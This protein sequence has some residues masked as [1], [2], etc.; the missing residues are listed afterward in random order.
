MHMQ[1][2]R[3]SL[4]KFGFD[5]NSL[6]FAIILFGLL[7][8]LDGYAFNR[9]LWIDESMLA[10]NIVSRSYTW[11]TQPLD[12]KQGAPIAFLI[13]EKLSVEIFGNRDYVL[14]IFPMMSGCFS[15]F[16]MYRL[17]KIFCESNLSI[18]FTI[19]MFAVGRYLVYYS[20]ELK[21]YSIDV[22]FTI[23][24]YIIANKLFERESTKKSFVLLGF[25]GAIA[26]WLSHP[27]IF[28]LGVCFALILQF[29]IEKDKKVFNLLFYIYLIAYKLYNFVCYFF[30][31][32]NR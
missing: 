27:S 6:A 3:G 5:A 26:P 30:A 7:L 8:R 31:R 16:L 13:I 28:I 18:L 32:F 10:L 25:V 20:L 29:G 19:G 21:Q 14:R 15:L 11:L 12:D 17:T 4:Q 23:L 24:I 22:M 1:K 2:F 9:S